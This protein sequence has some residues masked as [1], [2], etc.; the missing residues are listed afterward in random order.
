[1]SDDEKNITDSQQ[2]A[3]QKTSSSESSSINTDERE[4]WD[5]ESRYPDEVHTKLK[6]ELGYLIFLIFVALLVIFLNWLGVFTG[7]LEAPCEK[8]TLTTYIYYL[9]SGLLGGVT[10]SGKYLYRV[11]GRGYWNQD[12]WVWRTLSPLLSMVIGFVIGAMVE[13]GVMDSLVTSSGA[14]SVVIGFLAGYFADKAVGFMCDIAD[15][16]FGKR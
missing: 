15:V 14:R 10:F 2:E 1:M 6:W 5:W 3:D 12:R 13:C 7:G 4:K 11:V 8:T 9:A 16:L